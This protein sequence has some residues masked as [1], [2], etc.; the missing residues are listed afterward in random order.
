M[1][2]Y[3]SILLASFLFMGDS[4][5]SCYSAGDL[6]N[7]TD[8]MEIDNIEIGDN[9]INHM[10]I[11]NKIYSEQKKYE[12]RNPDDQSALFLDLIDYSRVEEL[13]ISAYSKDFSLSLKKIFPNLKKIRIDNLEDI[14]IYDIPE[15]LEELLICNSTISINLIENCKNLKKLFLGR[16]ENN[17][18]LNEI[19]ANSPKSLESFTLNGSSLITL[20][21]DFS[22][23]LPNL[24]YLNIENN[25]NLN[26]VLDNKIVGP[27]V[28]TLIL[29]N[30]PNIKKIDINWKP[31]GAEYITVS[32][33]GTFLDFMYLPYG[34]VDMLCINGEDI[35]NVNDFAKRFFVHSG[36]WGIDNPSD[37]LHSYYPNVDIGND[38]LIIIQ[39]ENAEYSFDLYSGTD[40]P[41]DFW[42]EAQKEAFVNLLNE[43]QMINQALINLKRFKKTKVANV[44]L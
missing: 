17:N 35:H 27:Y 6:S 9:F 3:K 1:K 23:M 12:I 10:D 8:D 24:K 36:V 2:I 19:L 25:P 18:M 30:S 29:N 20:P 44:N 11:S 26:C 32:G 16:I 22:E 31:I 15:C 39:E 42:T 13:N 34:K 14:E 37:Y 43:A 33:E 28:Q 38:Q 40:A 21:E 7:E 5:H 4:Y 41:N